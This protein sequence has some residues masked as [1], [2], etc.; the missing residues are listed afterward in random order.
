MLLILCL[1]RLKAFYK[2][3][4]IQHITPAPYN[5]SSNGLAERAVRTLKEG[6]NKFKSGSLNTRVC[7]FL[8]NYRKSVHSSIHKSP[9]EL[10]FG[11]CFKTTL[12]SV[13]CSP[14][15]DR[16]LEKLSEKLFSD[17]TNMY[18]VGDAVFAKN[19][20]KGETWIE[21]KITQVLGVRNY[22]VQ[23]HDFGNISWKRHHDQ[24]MPRFTG[25]SIKTPRES[26]LPLV[27]SNVSN[28]TCTYSSTSDVDVPLQNAD[29]AVEPDDNCIDSNETVSGTGKYGVNDEQ[30]V[31]S[32]PVLRRSKRIIKPPEKINL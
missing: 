23:V 27:S 26:S 17:G 28:H 29:V 21:G 8:Y 11:R 3:N 7:R 30:I 32:T 19:L 20:G 15:K 14:N 24:L 18:K 4:G 22:M 6:L 16:G 13:K 9:A 12:E 25:N 10:L 1:R 2:K 31:S 5:P